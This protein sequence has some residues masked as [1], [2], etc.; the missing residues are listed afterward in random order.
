[1][2][3]CPDPILNALGEKYWLFHLWPSYTHLT[4]KMVLSRGAFH[5]I[6]KSML[7][8]TLSVGW[9][10]DF[11]CTQK[12]VWLKSGIN[13]QT[14]VENNNHSS[15]TY[16]L[17]FQGWITNLTNFLELYILFFS[18]AVEASTGNGSCGQI[19]SFWAYFP[20]GFWGDFALSPKR[21]L[22]GVYAFN[23]T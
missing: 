10:L 9:H 14:Q 6:R 2:G 4:L 16:T 15:F 5:I 7:S 19:S 18:G 12:P 3:F 23:S 13:K 11:V 17:C 21:E 8:N 22:E 20:Q 1:M